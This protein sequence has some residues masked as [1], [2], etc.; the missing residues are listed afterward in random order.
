MNA[1][2]LPGRFL[3]NLISDACIGPLNTIIPSTTM[4]AL[5]IFLWISSTTHTSLLITACLYGFAAAGLQSLY[6]ATVY[7]F[8]PDLSKAGIRM[9]MVFVVIGIACLTGAPVG[10]SLIDKDNGGYLY[11][12]IFSGC[13]ILCGAAF[14][15]A[16]RL[17]K[18]GWGPQR[19]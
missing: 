19:V 17:V 4:A 6:N 8:V 10:G 2:N 16:A 3:P 12:Q 18:S 15:L 11:A 14:L 7:S 5:F 13:S 9:A 1:A